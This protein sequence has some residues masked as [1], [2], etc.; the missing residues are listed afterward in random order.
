MS[1]IN[2]IFNLI[3]GA[4]MVRPAYGLSIDDREADLIAVQDIGH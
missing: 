4:K 1:S 3:F 2:L